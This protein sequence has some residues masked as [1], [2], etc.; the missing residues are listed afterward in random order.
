[1]DTQKEKIVGR[2]KALLS[3]T[4]D[5]G[6]S[7]AESQTAMNIAASLMEKHHLTEEDLAHEPADDYSKV[8]QA[9]FNEQ[10]SFVGSVSFAWE[11][12]LASFVSE[13]VGCP[14]YY[15]KVKR[16]VRKNGFVQFK[17]DEPLYGASMVFYGIPEDAAIACEIY[18]ELRMLIA[19][20][21]VGRFGKVYRGDGAAYS[22]GF[23][24]GLRTK[25]KESKNL[26]MQTATTSTS[27]ILIHRRADLVKYK[28]KKATEWL[29]KTKGWKLSKGYCAGSG[30]SRR[31]RGEGYVDGQNTDVTA[32]RRRKI[33]V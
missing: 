4:G 32:T 24:S 17:N 1:M 7:D 3:K 13:F 9:N 5:N 18:D 11:N 14:S 23:V 29:E 21:A 10:R 27:M 22:E 6:A 30:A 33:G 20:M 8:D 19:S 15:D 16:P 28:E 26:E 2:I 12:Y 25:L 31:A